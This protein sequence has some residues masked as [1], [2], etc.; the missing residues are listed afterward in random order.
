MRVVRRIYKLK[1]YRGYK[2]VANI[3]FRKTFDCN[4]IDRPVGLFSA[5]V[6]GICQVVFHKHL[7]CNTCIFVSLKSGCAHEW[8]LVGF[9]SKNASFRDGDEWWRVSL[10]VEQTVT[11]ASISQA[12]WWSANYN[13]ATDQPI[14]NLELSRA[15]YAWSVD[16]FGN[17]CN[18]CALFWSTT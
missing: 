3:W 8:K 2:F 15:Q 13:Q 5:R 7:P 18:M 1:K 10:N 4:K 9:L 12:P 17:K 14:C 16:F 6:S 11:W